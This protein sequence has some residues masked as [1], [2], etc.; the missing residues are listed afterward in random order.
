M[1]MRN[2]MVSIRTRVKAALPDSIAAR[3]AGKFYRPTSERIESNRW[4][5]YSCKD[6]QGDILS[7]GSGNDADSQGNY[8]RDYFPM[9]S[10]YTTS[11]A[12]A[13][14]ECDL[15]LDVRSMPELD[16]GSFDCI[17]CSG[18]LEH[19]DDYRTALDEITRILKSDGILL[20]G[21]PFR[22]SIHMSPQDFWRFTEFG[23]RYL[24]QDSYEIVDLAPISQ[25][26][27][28]DFPATYWVKAIK[29]GAIL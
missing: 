10:S 18:V 16:D 6:I 19:V 22:Q 2:L 15:V 25:K 26:R 11:E 20:L 23:I 13:A 8:Y 17:Y 7:I 21:L 24:L 9:A 4:L 12:S 29:L 1:A 14:F 27:G 28:M 3:F 5:R